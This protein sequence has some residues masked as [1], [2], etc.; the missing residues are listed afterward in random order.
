MHVFPP[1]DVKTFL[2]SF[3][4]DA[5]PDPSAEHHLVAAHVVI[6]DVLQLRHESFLVDEEEVDPIIC[7]HLDSNIALD[8]E[9]ETSD[10]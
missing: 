8:E 3:I 9:Y 6:H 10:A 1:V 5:V 4:C 2:V 7:G